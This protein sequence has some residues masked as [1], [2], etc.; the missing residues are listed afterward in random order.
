MKMKMKKRKK[1]RQNHQETMAEQRLSRA[2]L[3]TEYGHRGVTP[4]QINQAP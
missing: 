1:K 2:G 3:A 4:P